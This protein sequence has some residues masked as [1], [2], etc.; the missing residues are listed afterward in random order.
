VLELSTSTIKKNNSK[1]D[2]G[3]TYSIEV[4]TARQRHSLTKS[5]GR[6]DNKFR[7]RF[8][9]SSSR[10]IDLVLGCRLKLDG[11][12]FYPSARP[13]FIAQN[14][15]HLLLAAMRNSTAEPPSPSHSQSASSCAGR[16]GTPKFCL[17]STSKSIKSSSTH[18]H[19]C[20]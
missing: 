11:L 8:E 17:A 20:C 6:A 2:I 5:Q 14:Q 19:R 15:Q 4:K 12:D 1:L 13:T 10:A 18:G 3:D 9:L 16:A 7:K